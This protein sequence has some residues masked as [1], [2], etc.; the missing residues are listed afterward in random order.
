MEVSLENLSVDIRAK[1]LNYLV[2]GQL[3]WTLAH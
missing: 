2:G 3:A 1:R